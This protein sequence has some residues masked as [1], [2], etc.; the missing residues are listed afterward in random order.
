M[1]INQFFL[2]FHVDLSSNH[3]R[4]LHSRQWHHLLQKLVHHLQQ[5]RMNRLHEFSTKFFESIF[6]CSNKDWQT[7]V[8]GFS[9]RTS[10]GGGWTST[11]AGGLGGGSSTV[12]VGS[13]TLVS[14]AVNSKSNENDE[15]DLKRKILVN[16]KIRTY[17]DPEFRIYSY[18]TNEIKFLFSQRFFHHLW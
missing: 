14:F 5:L 6:V 3:H 4:L 7:V 2:I 1:E 8:D 18:L 11:S 17:I 16:K 12:T 13:G 15:F 9:W 10:V